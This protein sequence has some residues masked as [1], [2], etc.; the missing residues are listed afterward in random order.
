MITSTSNKQMKHLQQLLKKSKC[1][2]EEAVFVIEG[3]KMFLEAPRDRIVKVYVSQSFYERDRKE[4]LFSGLEVEVVE[5]E[6]FRIV[7]DTKTPQGIIAIVR[8]ASYNIEEMLQSETPNLIILENIQDPGNLGTI[9][10][11]AEGAGV[12][13]IIASRN[14]VDLYNPKTIRSTMGSIYRMPILFV[15]D[16][17]DILPC[18]KERNITTYAAHLAG[19]TYYDQEDYRGGT[20]LIIGNEGNG[21][22][23]Q[24]ANS[25]DVLIR[26][27]MEG[28]VE[29]LNAAM[30]A[31]ILMYEVYRQRR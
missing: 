7:S 16:L 10:R 18:L 22:S 24:L 17:I 29:S 15:E 13:G 27:P 23:E 5:D 9:V 31:G 30:A 28:K 1:R 4:E 3:V 21:I 8:Q 2:K 12:T 19:T 11:T 20:A 26:I 14:T 25:T 6:V